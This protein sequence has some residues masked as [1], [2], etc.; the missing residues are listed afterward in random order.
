VLP[1]KAA[2]SKAPS[3][4]KESKPA[5]VPMPPPDDNEANLST[6]RLDGTVK[7]LAQELREIGRKLTKVVEKNRIALD[8]LTIKLTDNR[9]ADRLRDS[10]RAINEE[11]AS[12]DHCPW[13][14]T[15]HRLAI[16]SRLERHSENGYCILRRLYYGASLYRVGKKKAL[17]G[18]AWDS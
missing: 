11:M 1:S 9:A 3:K 12:W 8:Y 17:S 2:E 7:H 16:T 13:R 4:P 15:C 14:R 18:I 10:E 5:T 6:I